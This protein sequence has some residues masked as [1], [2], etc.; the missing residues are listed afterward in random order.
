[1]VMVTRKSRFVVSS[2][3]PTTTS[4]LF[5]TGENGPMTPTGKGKG[6]GKGKGEP[7]FAGKSG[8]NSPSLPL[9]KNPGSVK[10]NSIVSVEATQNLQSIGP[11]PG[12]GIGICF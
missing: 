5:T 6:G 11:I 3:Y 2:K 10:M 1:M 8:L 9:S 4:P 7:R 12:G